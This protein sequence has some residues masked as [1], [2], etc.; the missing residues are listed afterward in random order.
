MFSIVLSR[1]ARLLCGERLLELV[2]QH[3]GMLLVETP[4]TASSLQMSVSFKRLIPGTSMLM[5]PAPLIVAMRYGRYALPCQILPGP[6]SCSRLLFVCVPFCLLPQL[7]L[8]TNPALPPAAPPRS[9]PPHRTAPPWLEGRS[10]DPRRA[11][12]SPAKPRSLPQSP[13]YPPLPNGPPPFLLH[14]LIRSQFRQS[15]PR[16]SHNM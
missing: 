8:L 10:R 9:A 14:V 6:R 5:R 16:R 11:P 15:W 4:R 12:Q 1:G 2:K 3:V 13:T 7:S